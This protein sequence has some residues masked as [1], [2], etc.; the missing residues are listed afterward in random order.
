MLNPNEMF[1]PKKFIKEVVSK[2][3]STIFE[4]NAVIAVSGGV[5]STVAAVLVGRV[6][7]DRLTAVHVDNGYMRRLSNGEYE[8]QWV[9]KVLKDNGVE[10]V[11]LIEAEE[12]FLNARLDLSKA[13]EEDFSDLDIGIL[14][15]IEEGVLTK[16]LKEVVHPEVKR[17]IIGEQ[18]IRVFEREAR[19]VNSGYLVQG[20]LAP[21]WIESGGGLR[22]NIKSHHNVGALPKDMNVTLFEPN[23]DIYKDEIRKVARELGLPKELS[24]RQPF[25]G[26]GLAIRVVNAPANKENVSIVREANYIWERTIDNAIEDG[27][28]KRVERQYLA[29]YFPKARTVGV[30]GDIR[31]YAGAVALRCFRTKD[32]MAGYFEKLPFNLIDKASIEITNTLKNH[33]NRVFYDCTNKPPGTTEFE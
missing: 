30:H 3:K 21:D 31:S 5:D 13:Y 12:E 33:V 24:E 27:I 14:N 1:N 15:E 7:G 6:I 17:K 23:R 26:P 20:T 19:K 16:P 32:Y 22:D 8:S 18:F 29:G 9:C 25:P 28:L 11:I 2:A 4:N 10:N